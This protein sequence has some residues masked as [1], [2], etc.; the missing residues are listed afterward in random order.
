M[1]KLKARVIRT[2]N[3][4]TRRWYITGTCPY[5]RRRLRESI[6]PIAATK[7]K[8]SQQPTSLRARRSGQRFGNGSALFAEA[9]VE[10]LGKKERHG[11]ST[12]CCQSSGG[13]AF[14]ISPT[15]I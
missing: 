12:R 14:V 3:G 2:Q 13:R 15:K 8:A 10:Y 5:T 11:F 6:E 9:V 1:L 7:R 4:E